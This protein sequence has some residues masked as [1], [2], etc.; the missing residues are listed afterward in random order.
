MQETT[1]DATRIGICAGQGDG[2]S[3]RA[4]KA[5]VDY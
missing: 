2:P 4:S 5:G 3:V 1:A